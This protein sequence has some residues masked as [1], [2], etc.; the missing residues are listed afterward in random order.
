MHARSPRSIDDVLA[1]DRPKY[2]RPPALVGS[3]VAVQVEILSCDH[4]E[5]GS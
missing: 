1:A 5:P 2:L 4:L 3:Q